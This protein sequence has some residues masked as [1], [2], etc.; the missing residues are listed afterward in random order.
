MLFNLINDLGEQ[1][2]LA[3][4]H[5]AIVARLSARMNKLDQEIEKNAR[6]PWMK[7]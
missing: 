7:N 2:N 6:S 1:N 5:P 4:E 3:S